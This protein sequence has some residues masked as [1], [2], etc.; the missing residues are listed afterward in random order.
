MKDVHKNNQIKF[1]SYI[2]VAIKHC[3]LVAQI[4]IN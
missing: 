2:G 1:G 4:E 3:K